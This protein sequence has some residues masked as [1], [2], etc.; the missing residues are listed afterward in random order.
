[1]SHCYLGLGGNVGDVVSAMDAALGLLD[2]QNEISV[3]QVSRAYE[4]APVGAQAGGEY[5]NA[6][7]A[8]DADLAPE[9][10]LDR[11]KATERGLGR[12]GGDRWTERVIDLD[13]L[14]VGTS[15]IDTPRLTVP[16]PH[17][18]YRRFVLDPLVEI[19]P[20]VVHPQFDETLSQLRSRLLPRPLELVVSTTNDAIEAAETASVLD[21]YR[22]LV[23]VRD[24]SAAV[25]G[26]PWLEF[27]DSSVTAKG[28]RRR[29]D[30]QALPGTLAEAIRSVVVA[31][32]DEPRVHKRPLR[33]IP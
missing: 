15:V 23:H 22:P 4:T 18:W 10:L 3:I 25:E 20:D 17:L 9:Q 31:A 29:V 24:A 6:A 19:A 1:M 26:G 28:Y 16:H 11:L 8:I 27:V 2:A 13:L 33:S 32:L 7:A 21:A 5:L 14:L 12:A 30:L